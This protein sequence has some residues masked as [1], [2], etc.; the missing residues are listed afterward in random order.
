M[1]RIITA[2]VALS[3]FVGTGAVAA[4]PGGHGPGPG[5]GAPGCGQPD[6]AWAFLN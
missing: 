2:R 4:Q 6:G 1:K 3:V 5:P